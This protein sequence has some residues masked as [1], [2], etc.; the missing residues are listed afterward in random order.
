MDASELDDPPGWAAPDEKRRYQDLVGLGRAY[1]VQATG[2][3]DTS[4]STPQREEVLFRM[5]SLGRGQIIAFGHDDP[6]T[7][8]QQPESWIWVFNSMGQERWSWYR[9]H[10]V[11]LQRENR[12]F[13]EFLI[14]GVGLAPVTAFQVLITLFV[15]AIGPV[16]FYLLQRW[17]KL[18]LI[19]VT[20]P[21]SAL[22]VTGALLLYALVADGLGVR[23]RARSLTEI[24]QRRG[25]AVCWTRLSYNAGL[26]PS[27]GLAF[28]TDTA[29]YPIEHDA[30]GN[31]YGQNR[32]RRTIDWGQ[33][34]YLGSGWLNARTPTQLLTVSVRPAAHKLTIK[35]TAVSPPV[36]ENLL[37]T[38]IQQL[39]LVDSNGDAFYAQGIAAEAKVALTPATS[40]Q[41]TAKLTQLHQLHRPQ[42]PP[43][44][45]NS[46][47]LFGVNRRFRN[48]Y[49]NQG[50][51]MDAVT[52]ATSILERGL[53]G[54]TER[55]RLKQPRSYVAIVDRSPEMS[56]GLVSVREEAGF[57][58]IV[59]KW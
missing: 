16:N 54:L 7:E 44:M 51:D 22:A 10:G 58:V 1:G 36:V 29:V 50:Y 15:L 31:Y 17:R 13:W 39:M 2:A 11:S 53:Q 52:Q 34:Q 55:D 40:A 20:V 41:N 56:F 6:L 12:D 32:Q 14:P 33:K 57:H 5:R 30:N 3:A 23:A 48:V 21:L 59:G 43:G 8:I 19:M 9:R 35:E 45:D 24:D 4:T 26:R 47:S 42:R 25:E 28:P 37:G 18:N 49:Y 38:R 46:Y 27:Q